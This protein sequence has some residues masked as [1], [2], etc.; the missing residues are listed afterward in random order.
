M[1]LGS[2]LFPHVL[3]ECPCVKRFFFSRQPLS[4]LCFPDGWGPP[5]GERV[6]QNQGVIPLFI[7][8]SSLGPNLCLY[9]PEDLRQT[10]IYWPA[11][12]R[13][14]GSWARDAPSPSLCPSVSRFASSNNACCQGS[15]QSGC[16]RRAVCSDSMDMEEC[17]LQG[18]RSG[19]GVAA[20]P[21]A[22]KTAAVRQHGYEFL[23]PPALH[24]CE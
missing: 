16:L 21:T 15:G 12:F 18:G 4:P 1:E 2:L 9:Y 8:A 13:Y 17:G 11:S 3:W 5:R 23:I 20:R 19:T 22:R 6:M 24:K 7:S 10:F 14:P